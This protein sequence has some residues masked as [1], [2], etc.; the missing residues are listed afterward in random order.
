[1]NKLRYYLYQFTGYTVRFFVRI[2]FRFTVER[3]Q[4]KFPR[5]TRVLVVSNHQSLYDIPALMN[6]LNIQFRWVIKKE[7]LKVPIFGWALF[8]GRNV[9]IDRSSTKKSIKSMDRA[10]RTLPSGVS[11][12]VFAEGTRTPDGLVQDFKKGGFIMALRGKVPILPVTVNGSWKYMPDRSSMSFTPGPI[13]VVV[14]D[15]IHTGEYTMKN[16]DQLVEKTR[17]AIIANLKPDFPD[18]TVK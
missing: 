8:I 9:F 14:G 18:R 10:M 1:M 6:G 5:V 2:F 17:N 12:F 11:V 13:E 4:K 15:P 3:K 16:L 7:I